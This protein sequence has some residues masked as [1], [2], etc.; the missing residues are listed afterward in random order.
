[1]SE[2][3]PQTEQVKQMFDDIAPTYDR[4]NHILSLSIDKLWR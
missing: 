4:L 3:K 2:V 1:M